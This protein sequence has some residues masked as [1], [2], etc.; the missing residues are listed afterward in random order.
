MKNLLV[1]FNVAAEDGVCEM[2]L[3]YWQ[4]S[5]CEILFSS[6]Q[7]AKSQL[8]DVSHFHAG[9]AMVGTK[10]SW[11]WYQARVLETMRFVKTLPQAGFVFTQYDSIA[12]DKLPFW[13]GCSCHV[14]RN[15][16]PTYKAEIFVHPPWC[17]DRQTLECFLDEAARYDI[18]TSEHGVMDRW[19]AWILECAK[20]QVTPTND[21]S[22]SANSI[23]RDALVRE[24]RDA[25]ARG[26][27]FIHG[28]KNQAQLKTI[29]A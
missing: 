3:P 15:N 19:M 28:V 5:G 25:I 22:W 23:D 4:R 27:R 12:L 18:A 29:L 21:W 10:A 2:F 6:P 24:C 16:D 7:D 1:V 11:W 8:N 17:F 9:K 13:S 20:I 26:A 14:F